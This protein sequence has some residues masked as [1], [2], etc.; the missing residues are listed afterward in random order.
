MKPFFACLFAAGFFFASLPASLAGARDWKA[1]AHDLQAKYED[2]ILS[3]EQLN[4]DTCWVV[5]SPSLSQQDA[6]RLARD[7]GYFI[8][9]TTGGPARGEKPEVHV[10]IDKRQIAVARPCGRWYVGTIH[11]QKLDPSFYKGK[12]RP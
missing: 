1:L 9:N 10:F 7:I 4:S 8:Q 12:F 5:L 11:I 6:A 3:I 2:Q